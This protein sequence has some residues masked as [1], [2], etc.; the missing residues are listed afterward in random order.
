MEEGIKNRIILILSLLVIMFI[1]ATASS[2]NN[3]YRQKLYRDKEM[4]ARLE[5]EEGIAK[6]AQEKTV[7]E[8]RLAAKEKELDEEKLAHQE[9][10]NALAKEQSENKSQKEELD[11]V[12]KLKEALEEN[13]KEALVTN[14]PEKSKK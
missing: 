9:T 8:E 5:L 7:L 13:L 14:K 11:K 2:C 12:T 1:I 10:K 4:A 6:S 3:A